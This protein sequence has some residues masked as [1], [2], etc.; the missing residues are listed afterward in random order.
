MGGEGGGGEFPGIGSTSLLDHHFC[1]SSICMLTDTSHLVLPSSLSFRPAL[2][3]KLKN[4]NEKVTQKL[5]VDSG[6]FVAHK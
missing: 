1:N 4:S 3:E 6:M 2:L 5:S